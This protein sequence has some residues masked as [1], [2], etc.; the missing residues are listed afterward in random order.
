MTGCWDRLH[1]SWCRAFG[2]CGSNRVDVG[3]PPPAWRVF[4]SRPGLRSQVRRVGS[5]RMSRDRLRAVSLWADG[6]A[7]PGDLLL[8]VIAKAGAETAE[9][10]EAVGDDGAVSAR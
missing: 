8:R 5:R 3:S 10:F 4:P 7:T 9:L 1:P 6:S 2:L